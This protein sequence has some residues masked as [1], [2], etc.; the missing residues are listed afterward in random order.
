[1][2]EPLTVPAEFSE[3]I[4][5]SLQTILEDYQEHG[6]VSQPQLEWLFQQTRSL[7][8]LTHASATLVNAADTYIASLKRDIEHRNE[9]ITDLKDENARLENDNLALLQEIAEEL[10]EDTRPTADA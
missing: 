9:E 10:A 7:E 4:Q 6:T 1:M 8:S 2:T 3:N 5:N